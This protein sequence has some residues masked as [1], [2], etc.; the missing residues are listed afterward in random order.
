MTTGNV[1]YWRCPP[2][3]FIC[4]GIVSTKLKCNTTLLT[5]LLSQLKPDKVNG[6]LT[7]KIFRRFPPMDPPKYSINPTLKIDPISPTET[8]D[9]AST[10]V[11]DF[12]LDKWNAFET[13]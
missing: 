4:T 5:L 6:G 1:R 12:V 13:K 9:Y 3:K 8:V 10:E 7:A 11:A 2:L